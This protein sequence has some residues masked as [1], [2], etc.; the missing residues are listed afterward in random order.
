M[1]YGFY[2]LNNNNAVTINDNTYFVQLDPTVYSANCYYLLDDYEYDSGYRH[3]K[4]SDVHG[5]NQQ[6][7]EF[8]WGINTN[9]F[10]SA[11]Y[12]ETSG[13]FANGYLPV[14]W[15]SDKAVPVASPWF[16][17][18]QGTTPVYYKRVVRMQAAADTY[19]LRLYNSSGVV[20]FDSG[21]S[22]VIGHTVVTQAFYYGDGYTFQN[23]SVTLNYPLP[24]TQ[25]LLF[26]GGA[27]KSI[28]TTQ[29]SVFSRGFNIG[30]T[31]ASF[32]ALPMIDAYNQPNSSGTWPIVVT[33]VFGNFL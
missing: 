17:C 29:A 12:N 1:S 10:F 4:I 27:R 24:L 7:G 20:T 9:C 3:A 5:V 32:S 23:R 30:T 6:D 18:A 19:G 31:S 11:E 22:F 13:Y 14:G 21:G 26:E 2:V 16:H 8:F 25:Y 15:Y 33:Y 28:G